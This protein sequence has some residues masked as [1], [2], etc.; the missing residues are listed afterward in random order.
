VTRHEVKFQ[1]DVLDPERR[2]VFLKHLGE[3]GRIE[4]SVKAAGYS[5]NTELRR[6]AIQN[7]EFR[8]QWRKA[9][10]QY[11]RKMDVH[12]KEVIQKRIGST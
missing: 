3:T 12:A 4:A 1:E 8:I 11:L 6:Y 5:Y 10:L 7:E 9:I 2:A